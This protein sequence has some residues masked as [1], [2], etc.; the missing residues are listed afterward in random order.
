MG[1]TKAQ[2]YN[3]N[4]EKLFAD[5]KALDDKFKCPRCGRTG[6]RSRGLGTTTD[7]CPSC[8]YYKFEGRK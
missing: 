4:M 3:R 8:G 2:R 6:I 7:S 1:L 5:V